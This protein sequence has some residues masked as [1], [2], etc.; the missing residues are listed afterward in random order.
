MTC[1]NR[2]FFFLAPTS[3]ASGC[4]EA[5]RRP[6][7]R[8]GALGCRSSI[9]FMRT[10]S[11]NAIITV[12]NWHIKANRPAAQLKQQPVRLS[13]SFV[14]ALL[15]PR[16]KP[17]NRHDYRKRKSLKSLSGGLCAG[18]AANLLLASVQP[19]NVPPRTAERAPRLS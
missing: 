14:A 5:R 7:A 13:C 11:T 15:G 19:P 16:G 6:A 4:T 9:R 2:S 8:Y 3:S 1:S 12:D 10:Y 18:E 17:G